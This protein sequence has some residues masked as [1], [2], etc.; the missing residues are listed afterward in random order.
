MC[1]KLT[2]QDH[3]NDPMI[4]K[5]L[6]SNFPT[7]N[8]CGTYLTNSPRHSDIFNDFEELDYFS[9]DIEKELPF[10]KHSNACEVNTRD[11]LDDLNWFENIGVVKC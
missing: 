5:N 4:Y 10:C 6:L 7:C 8:H 3:G 11:V 2:I 9:D 1:N